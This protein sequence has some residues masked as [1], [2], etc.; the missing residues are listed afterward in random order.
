[1]RPA[2]PTLA[3]SIYQEQS[4]PA[5]VWLEQTYPALIYDRQICLVPT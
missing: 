4:C 2:I 5:L 3:V 1:M